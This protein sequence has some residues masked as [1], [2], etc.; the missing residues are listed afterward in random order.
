MI[1]IVVP[2]VGAG[3]GHHVI[4]RLEP[5]PACSILRFQGYQLRALLI[6][7]PFDHLNNDTFR[8]AEVRLSTAGLQFSF[9]KKKGG[10]S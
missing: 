3:G 9:R 6:S 1:R 7:F 4:G 2:Q 10:T 5:A 8:F